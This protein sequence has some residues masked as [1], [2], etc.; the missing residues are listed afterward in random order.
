[1][2]A[3]RKSRKSMALE[4]MQPPS[5]RITRTVKVMEG[6]V[7]SVYTDHELEGFEDGHEGAAPLDA[8]REYA[9]SSSEN[10]ESDDRPKL[11]PDSDL[12][13]FNVL[14]P[15]AGLEGVLGL[16]RQNV[17]KLL[18]RLHH[19]ERAHL[20]QSLSEWYHDREEQGALLE[21]EMQVIAKECEAAE[22]SIQRPMDLHID[23]D[24][25]E[26]ASTSRHVQAFMNQLHQHAVN[27]E[28]RPEDLEAKLQEAKEAFE[29]EQERG[30]GEQRLEDERQKV[31]DLREELYVLQGAR[32]R[33]PVWT[34]EAVPHD[35]CAGFREDEEEVSQDKKVEQLESEVEEQTKTYEQ[36]FAQASTVQHTNLELQ[37]Y[38]AAVR[39][40]CRN[41]MPLD[42]IAW[43]TIMNTKEKLKFERV[44][45]ILE[46]CV[47]ISTKADY[48][49]KDQAAADEAAATREALE[50]NSRPWRRTSRRPSAARAC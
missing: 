9:S 47:A 49:T 29:K 28:D 24:S 3:S 45:E 39:R 2:S 32:R 23:G 38:I 8:P 4:E 46:R 42:P 41:E 11:G 33:S 7:D 12:D 37:S 27:G 30:R 17:Q 20:F 44:G 15:T 10:Q 26:R 43:D 50:L 36:V 13:D 18:D 1:M 14:K 21:Q 22:K 48:S 5:V 6:L 19:N 34:P 35:H 40:G 16:S 31:L 25:E